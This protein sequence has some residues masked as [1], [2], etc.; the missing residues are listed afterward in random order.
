MKIRRDHSST[1]NFSQDDFVSRRLSVLRGMP[2][3]GLITD[4]VIPARHW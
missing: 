4:P 2:D 1:D 3:L